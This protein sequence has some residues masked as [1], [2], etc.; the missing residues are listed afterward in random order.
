MIIVEFFFVMMYFI[1]KALAIRKHGEFVQTLTYATESLQS[2]VDRFNKY[3]NPSTNILGSDRDNKHCSMENIELYATWCKV[4]HGE[5][6]SEE[7]ES[8]IVNDRKLLQVSSDRTVRYTEDEDQLK[9]Q[10]IY[11]QIRMPLEIVHSLLSVKIIQNETDDI[12]E[13]LQQLSKEIQY[14]PKLFKEILR[15]FDGMLKQSTAIEFVTIRP[16]I[17]KLEDELD[18]LLSE[19]SNGSVSENLEKMVKVLFKEWQNLA[20]ALDFMKFHLEVQAGQG[21][22]DINQT[23]SMHINRMLDLM[24][25]AEMGI[26]LYRICR[27][28]SNKMTAL[29]AQVDGFGMHLKKWKAYEKSMYKAI[30]P[31]LKTIEDGSA[32]TQFFVAKMY[33]PFLDGV[34]NMVEQMQQQPFVGHNLEYIFKNLRMAIEL[35]ERLFEQKQ[36]LDDRDTVMKLTQGIQWPIRYGDREKHLNMEILYEMVISNWML[37]MCMIAHETIKIGTFPFEQYKLKLCDFDGAIRREELKSDYVKRK[38]LRNIESIG[39]EENL[40]KYSIK[41]EKGDYTYVKNY[42]FDSRTV[43]FYTWKHKDFKNDITK[44]LKGDDI[45]LHAN[46]SSANIPNPSYYNA[47]K[48][49]NVFLELRTPNK[50]RQSELSQTFAKYGVLMTMIGDQYYQCDGKV[51]S[52]SNKLSGGVFFYDLI[53]GWMN[54]NAVMY[55]LRQAPAHL[56]PYTLWNFRLNIARF[57]NRKLQFEDGHLHEFADDEID[58]QLSGI[59][60]FIQNSQ[61]GHDVCNDDELNKNYQLDRILDREQLKD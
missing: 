35:I 42:A 11:H 18:R 41:Q 12:A 52:V 49:N 5:N 27:D 61:Y 53:G 20:D 39:A 14:K 58:L 26:E 19:K 24:K 30:V 37:E 6:V 56:S 51:F 23:V 17:A 55:D 25:C 7:V 38:I 47:I 57:D 2:Y 32:R 8:L 44:L 43:P 31:V 48:F 34:D 3:C 15:D 16:I 54:M 46:M 13:K 1:G 9:T 50:T 10:M 29:N 21:N 4:F 36:I 60:S 28:D 59:G 40:K 22:G 45:F 33:I